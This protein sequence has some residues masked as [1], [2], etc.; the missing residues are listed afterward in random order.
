MVINY[1]KELFSITFPPK[2]DRFLS[3][4][5]IP[6]IISQM[7]QRLLKIAIEDEVREV[8]F[9]MHPEK[10]SGPDGMTTFFF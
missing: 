9:M 5:T 7:N 3:E 8:L 6:D 4:I 10:A 2:F 1:F